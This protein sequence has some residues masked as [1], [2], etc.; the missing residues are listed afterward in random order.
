MA[1]KPGPHDIAQPEPSRDFSVDV[2]P[3]P[4][5]VCNAPVIS[6]L[7][8][9]Q[10]TV[11]PTTGT[12]TVEL[13]EGWKSDRTVWAFTDVNYHAPFTPDIRFDTEAPIG[14]YSG[15][16]ILKGTDCD[17]EREVPLI[18]IG[19]GGPVTY[20]ESALDGHRIVTISTGLMEIDVAPSFNGTVSAIRD[21]QGVNQ[22]ASA[23]PSP[24]A[25]N[26]LYPWYGGITPIIDG[27]RDLI[28]P[29]LIVNE[30]FDLEKVAESDGRGT[31]WTGVRQRVVLTHE[32]LLGLSLE[33]DTLTLGGSPVVRLVWRFRNETASHRK[34]RTGWQVFVQPDGDR[35][36]TT[37]FCEDHE[38]KHSPRTF[39]TRCGH[40]VGAENPA[41]GRVVAL[42]S[43]VPE[44]QMDNWGVAGGHLLL[45]PLHT[46]PANS[47]SVMV[48]HVVMTNSRDTTRV[49]STMRHYDGR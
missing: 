42:I 28:P 5:V 38:R 18:R 14:A 21:Q 46:I 48:G 45:K 40:W 43:S 10:F 24:A 34:I 44:V 7:R 37:L 17:V 47:T 35:S 33:L 1:G 26:W 16:L 3:S 22:L 27:G 2:E 36:R 13:P 9:K 15:R 41:T 8:I 49:W 19:D 4:V 11:R 6:V 25:F 12:V 32:E 30:R 31:V 29:G 39:S 20:R 23:F